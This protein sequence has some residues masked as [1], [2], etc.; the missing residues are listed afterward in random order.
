MVYVYHRCCC[1]C[2]DICDYSC[3]SLDDNDDAAVDGG[4]SL[5]AI[6]RRAEKKMV[7]VGRVLQRGLRM[8]WGSP[9]NARRRL[10]VLGDARGI[11]LT[12]TIEG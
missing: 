11:H 6:I 10:L 12:E 5:D 9:A 8:K 4:D 1:C 3:N 7:V 2:F